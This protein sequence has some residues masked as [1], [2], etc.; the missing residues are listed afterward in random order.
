MKI[1]FS[2]H[3]SKNFQSS[4]WKSVHCKP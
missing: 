2:T 1:R 3:I 4:P